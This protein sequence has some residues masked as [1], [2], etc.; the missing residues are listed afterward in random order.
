MA[1]RAPLLLVHGGAGALLAQLDDDRRRQAEAGLAQAL[2]A[3]RATLLT[4]G[5]A[6]QAVVAAVTVLEDDAAFNA[7]HG[8]VFTAEGR[9]ELD[10]AVM[11]GH[12]RAAGA[13]AAVTCV[14]HPVQLA[15]RVLQDSPHVMLAG[16]GA[17]AFARQQGVACVDNSWFDTPRRAAEWQAWRRQP[18]TT[19]YYGTVGAVA[20]D[21]RGHLA[22]ATSTGGMT[23]KRWGRIGDSPLIGAGT[24]ADAHAAV[25]CTGW[26]EYFIRTCAAHAI[27][28]RIAA[29]Q[30]PAAASAALLRGEIPRL[31][32]SGGAIVITPRGAHALGFGTQGMYR[33][34]IA[35]QGG[36][37]VGIGRGALRTWRG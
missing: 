8:A 9:H 5:N 27:A 35:A 28:M 25:S 29:G 12:G 32:G 21:A 14:Q 1:E 19:D 30:S 3:G 36:P 10:A 31:G 26:G 4:G 17:E 13:V 2:L 15:L 22:A 11:D 37:R 20:R 16:A 33:G 24:W 23:G 6:L 18:G 34:A 7:G